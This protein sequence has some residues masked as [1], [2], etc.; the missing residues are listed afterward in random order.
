MRESLSLFIFL[1]STW[2]FLLVVLL[3]ALV[4]GLIWWLQDRE[5]EPFFSMFLAFAL[6]GLSTWLLVQLYSVVDM[7]FLVPGSTMEIFSLSVV[8][9]VLKALMLILCIELTQKWFTQIVDGLVYGAA[10][11]LGFAF[12]ENLYYLVPFLQSGTDFYVIYAIRSLN[13]MVAHSLFTGLFGFFYANAYLRE[14]VFPEKKRE[15]P[16]HHFWKNLWEALP[17]HVTLF[18]I[19][20]DRPSGHGHYPGSLIFEGLL[21]A[22]LLH[23]AFNCLLQIEIYGMDLSFM[24]FPFVFALAYV[25]WRLFLHDVYAKLVNTWK[26]A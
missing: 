24:S 6:G 1:M 2:L 12:V 14:E 13:T 16:W 10:V 19:L 5:K 11:A 21:M 26:R 20:P 17:L 3:P 15:K 18:H 8:E 22:S 23:G 7:S 4:W 25:I 9:E